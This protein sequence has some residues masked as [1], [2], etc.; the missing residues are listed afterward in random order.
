[1]NFIWLVYIIVPILIIILFEFLFLR[2]YKLKKKSNY[3]FREKINLDKISV[4]SHPYLPFIYKK[5]A[6]VRGGQINY[7]LNKSIEAP[8]LKLNSLRFANGIKSR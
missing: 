5:N 3:E 1:M 8:N 6:N 2:F 7:P 4:E